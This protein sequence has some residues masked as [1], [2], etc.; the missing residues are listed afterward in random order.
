MSIRKS[1]LRFRLW[2]ILCIMWLYCA[3]YIFMVLIRQSKMKHASNELK[4][5]SKNVVKKKLSCFIITMNKSLESVQL[6]NNVTCHPFIGQSVNAQ[7][8]SHVDIQIQSNLRQGVSS[9]GAHYTNNK[10]VSIAW[11][12]M[13]LWKKL[14]HTEG[15]EDYLIF[16][17][18]AYITN[19]SI[20]VYDELH[21]SGL[22]TNNYIIKL[23]NG[24][25][26]K[27]L[28]TYELVTLKMFLVNNIQYVLKK[29]TCSTRQNFFNV[30]AYVIDKQASRILLDKFF[31]MQYHVDIYLHYTGYKFSNLFVVENDV[32]DF[33]GRPSTHQSA[34]EKYQRIFPEFK[35]QLINIFSS[36]C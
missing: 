35:E 30:G 28:G 11:N 27:W 5:I 12:H 1:K 10:S 17:D 2:M 8:L 22:F 9:R 33:S 4:N 3:S 29:C 16:E 24:Y 31:P 6:D 25:R 34:E 14:A 7:I 18:D 15:S 36:D 26:M 19:H 32:V 20:K 13:Q 21:K 23:V